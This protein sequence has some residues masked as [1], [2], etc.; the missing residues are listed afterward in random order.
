MVD[1]LPSPRP[2]REA[3]AFNLAAATYRRMFQVE[4]PDN[5]DGDDLWGAAL[6]GAARALARF[7]ASRGVQFRT[8]AIDCIRYAI[9]EEMRAQG[10]LPLPMEIDP[11]LAVD[12]AAAWYGCDWRALVARLPT[13]ERE[14]IHRIYWEGWTAAE[15]ARDWGRHPTRLRQLRVQAEARLRR[16][17]LE[18]T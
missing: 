15:I 9:M 3:Y 8:W 11:A 14:I 16:W 13:R 18:D 12:T 1:L 4:H 6:L 17:A 10:A 2:G 7:D 5:L